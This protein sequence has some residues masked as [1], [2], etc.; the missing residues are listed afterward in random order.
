MFPRGVL[1]PTALASLMLTRLKVSG[2]KNLRNVDVS[3]GPFTCIAGPNASGKSN[4]FDAIAFLSYLADGT[5]MEAASRVRGDRSRSFDPRNLFHR[6][7]DTTESTM[8]FEVEMIVPP[9]GTDSLGQMAQAT[10]TFL[11]YK[12]ALGLRQSRSID[13]G[14]EIEV[15]F[16]EL[17]RIKVGDAPNHVRFPHAKRWLSSV[18]SGRRQQPFISTE[19]EKKGT[20][21]KI[22]QD[23]RSGRKRE[24]LATHLPRTALSSAD[25][26]ETPTAVLARQEMES[27]RE[28]QL[29]PS[30]L[31]HPSN[32]RDARTLGMDGSNLAATVA[33]LETTAEAEASGRGQDV[34]A[35]LANRLS[36]LI[37]DVGGVRVHRDETREMITVLV[38]DRL[39]TEHPA[40]SLSDGT[41]RFLALSVLDADPRFKGVLCLE[42]PENGIHP[43][44]IQPMLSLLRDIAVDVEEPVGPDN[45]LR[46][47]VINTHS[48]SVVANVQ[49][50]ELLMA[51]QVLHRGEKGHTPGAAFRWLSKTWRVEQD[52]EVH[53]VSRGLLVSYLSPHQD[54]EERASPAGT[55]A[56][57]RVKEREDIRQLRLPLVG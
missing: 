52:P 3:L 16:E 21:V 39:G 20:I 9:E 55:S 40:R 53:T 45:P 38:Q 43:D 10:T 26:A 51:V 1:I 49:D 56:R 47:V 50:D 4:L 15:L 37:D 14:S 33:H 5:L 25:A 22:H 46:Q 27:W 41:L 18:I 11:S 17:D 2:F 57:P 54:E 8:R 23:Q 29:E 19:E 36:A 28:L 35:Q 24:L 48:P 34:L 32:F 44:R 13:H 30:A 6:I 31:R 7:G 42:E 12:L